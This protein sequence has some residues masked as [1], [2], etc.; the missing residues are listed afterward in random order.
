VLAL[1]LVAGL[2]A[3][4]VA[5]APVAGASTPSFE[6]PFRCG[7]TWYG[8]TRDGTHGAA[9]DFNSPYP[10]HIETGM[11]V[12]AS[13]AG[14]VT[15]AHRA[16]SWGGGYGY[17][18]EIDHGGGWRTRYAHLYAPPL[19][20]VGQYVA[21]GTHLGGVGNT[22]NSFGAHLH[23]EQRFDGAKAWPTFR[24]VPFDLRNQ[25]GSYMGEAI[26][27]GNGCVVP[28]PDPCGDFVDTPA[29]NRFCAAILWAAAGGI[30][31]GYEDGTFR[32]TEAVSRQALAAF[33]F[34]F[35]RAQPS[36]P[37]TYTDVDGAHRFADEIG[38]LQVAGIAAGYPDGSF[39]PTVPIT[40]QA[41]AS[42]LWNLA[43]RP[44]AP[45]TAFTDVPAGHPFA[46]AIAWL[47][48]TG[49]TTGWDDGTFRPGE[50][51][52]RQAM[53]AFLQRYAGA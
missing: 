41:M 39:R 32:P 51:L 17:W 20:S 40:R 27:S 14:T 53:V 16:D 22:G 31:T 29:S 38:W 9:I 35:Q 18:V 34:R 46:G 8:G 49:I 37:P 21:V 28:V 30:T 42:F 12:L 26:V 6:V 10:D 3:T 52:S 7:E 23:Y 19:V 11:P 44:G 1:A 43:G 2:V 45:P 25:A 4:G 33:L 36:F 5:Q 48:A 50:P 15:V 24:G 13:A 47:S